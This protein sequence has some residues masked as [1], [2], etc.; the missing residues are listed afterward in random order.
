MSKLPRPSGRSV[1]WRIHFWA[2]LIASPFVFMAVVTGILYVF[3]PQLEASL[4][5]WLDRVT[6]VGAMRPLDDAVA[7]AR[8]AAPPGARLQSVLPA[9]RP[10][11]AVRATFQLQDRSPA[12]AEHHHAPAQ[13]GAPVST[14]AVHVN[15]YTAQVI[16]SIASEERF[17]N[18]AKRLHS[19]LL[20]GDGWRWMIELAASAMLVMLIT[21][22]ALWWPGAR[23]S[24]QPA[25]TT[26]GRN[27]WK[28]W[29]AL[30]GVALSVLTLTILLTGLTWSKYAGSQ[31]R[32]LRDA[33]GQASPQMPRDLSSGAANGRSPLSWQRAWSAARE[34]TPDVQMQLIAPRDAQGV[35]RMSGAD[36]GQPFKRF[37][38]LL[39]AYDGSP[40]YAAAWEQQSLFGKAT[41]VGIPFHRGE[42]GWWNQAL[43]LLFG[44]GVLVSLVTGWAMYFK[45]RQRGAGGLPRVPTGAWRAAA[46]SAWPAGLVL[47]ALMPV[48]AVVVGVIGLIEVA[49][50]LRPAR[51]P[52]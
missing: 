42:L 35:W 39:D 23:Q 40:L 17:G 47:C 29:H 32:S 49:L 48:L 22:I 18:W 30:L 7:A 26:Q 11:A 51:Q 16:G 13:P 41:G 25:A 33:L 20:Q 6:P 3:T 14:L 43:L 19:R 1:L 36:P 8:A 34:H 46:R 15:P 45:R 28:R 4:H 37:D 44:A 38:L 31:V 10:G 50:L 27:A 12:H 5:G 9:Y 52:A 21:G 24:L 2:A